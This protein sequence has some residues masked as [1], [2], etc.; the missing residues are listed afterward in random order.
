MVSSDHF[1]QELK[2]QLGRAS[3]RGANHLL[4]NVRDLHCSLGDFAGSREDLMTCRLAMR[5][6]M[7]VGDVLIVTEDTQAG[8]TVRYA[9]PR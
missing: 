5:S 2:A 7:V 6:E 8:M 9:L 3:S 4:V 1:Q